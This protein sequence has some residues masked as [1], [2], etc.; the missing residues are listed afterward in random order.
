[1]V[2]KRWLVPALVTG[3]L[4]LLALLA[5]WWLPPLLVF[6]GTNSDLIQGLTDLVQLLLWVVAGVAAL[7]GLWQGRRAPHP[8]PS[9]RQYGAMLEG[10]GAIAQDQSIAVGQD[11]QAV[12]DSTVV[13]DVIG[14]GGRK[15]THIHENR[16]RPDAEALL[17]AYLNRLVEEVRWL[18]LSGV[19][20]ALATDAGR[21]R[22]SLARVYTE[23]D[24]LETERGERLGQ[25]Q[26]A[27]TEEVVREPQRVPVVEVM[28]RE[29]HLVLLG[30]PGSGKST[31]ANFVTLCL[32]GE[33]L[34]LE[35]VN[36]GQ[37]GEAWT[38]R[39]LLP[40]RVVL[41]DFV[42]RGLP[43]LGAKASGDHLWRFLKA[44]LGETLADFAS[45][46]HK[47][48]Q[49]QGGLVLLDGF[50]EVP[51]A[52]QRRQQVMDAVQ[53]FAR[54]FP[55]CRFLLT[56]R[57]YA[58]QRQAWRLP[59]FAEAVLAPF[60]DE[61]IET[62]VDR[63]YAHVSTLRKGEMSAE[64]AQGRATLLKYAIQHAPG[65]G[66]L[67]RRPLLLTLMSSLHAWRG[68]SLPEKREQ[69]YNDTLDLLL[70]VWE[71]PKI[72]RNAQGDEVVVHQAVRE[73]LQSPRDRLLKALERLGYEAHAGQ[74]ALEGTADVPE[75][76]LVQALWEIRGNPD[77][78]QER[79]VEFIRD[80]AGLLVPHGVGVYT[81][82]HRTFQEYLAARYLTEANW[83]ETM[84]TLVR[85]V[86]ERWREVALLA[87]AKAARGASYAVWG[88][89]EALAPELPPEDPEPRA[90][91]AAF[92]GAAA[93]VENNL[94]ASVPRQHREKVAR[95][96]CWLVA[97]LERA[98]LPPVERAAAG[99]ALAKLGDPRPGVGVDPETGL[100][101]IIW[102]YVPHG[103]FVMG[104][105][106]DPMAWDDE[107]PQHTRDIPYDY[108]IS[109]YPVTVAQ[110]HPF[111]EDP[112]GYRAHRWWTKAGLKWREDRGKLAEYGEPYNL[113][114]HPMVGVTW[115][116]AVAFTCWLTEKLRRA[117]RLPKGWVV[118][119]PSEAEWEKGARGGL[120]I[121]H[122]PI[123]GRQPLASSERRLVENPDPKRRY[124]WGDAPDP[125]RANYEDRGIGTTSTVGCF[126]GGASPYG[127]VD[128]SGNVWEWC[129]TKW[130]DSYKN[131]RGDNDLEGDVPR[132]VRGGA[133]YSGE[134]SVRCAS[135]L[136]DLPDFQHIYLGLRLVVA[137]L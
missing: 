132:V 26:Q 48:L 44:E 20:P 120:Q 36:L 111:V 53:G 82:P 90:G 51:E 133:F 62:F 16:P 73:W 110:F 78:R 2:K 114:N 11:G 92:I 66:E 10:P 123:V 59:G 69:L 63:W 46:L 122:A 58:W 113:P 7:V 9:G 118:R 108:W 97:V 131:Y 52:E 125:N 75:A 95:L 4:I 124:P 83:P 115:Y 14:P 109:R 119:L 87:A 77:L 136:R 105:Q 68:G 126:P 38:H 37:L 128:L 129:A 134:G 29:D 65:L 45:L 72:V 96:Q 57:T 25:G 91:W 50:D 100:P 86:P 127:V 64:E 94:H 103:P 130:Q 98:L 8:R 6:V 93:L 1:M 79:I 22:L 18:N 112:A 137:P 55:R 71:Q 31:F 117:S 42:A 74:P 99:N 17:T 76:K 23:L 13:G 107:Q 15:E 106:D 28:N 34:N 80:R 3:G 33:G 49:E 12:V 5:R 56:S 19:D 85:A 41:R 101:D 27:S 61:Q 47:H 54:D 24:T 21:A 84:A 116:E 121:L 32:A 88:L 135:R 39:W 40:V 81:F 60:S 35:E 30:D 89:V 102:C 43:P 67:A 70:N 104:S